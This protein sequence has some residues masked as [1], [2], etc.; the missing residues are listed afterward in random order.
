MKLQ[1][2]TTLHASD[3]IRDQYDTLGCITSNSIAAIEYEIWQF[4][5]QRNLDEWSG[6]ELTLTDFEEYINGL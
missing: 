6:D 2:E 4:H 1:S 3:I 5:A